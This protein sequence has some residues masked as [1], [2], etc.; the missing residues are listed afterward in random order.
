MALE[1]SPCAGPFRP[2]ASN[3][4]KNLSC[5]EKTLSVTTEEM[6][7]PVTLDEYFDDINAMRS[8]PDIETDVWA[9]TKVEDA[10]FFIQDGIEWNYACSENEDDFDLY[11]IFKYYK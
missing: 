8:V 7:Q 6:L 9:K 3:I 4:R 5:K 11:T 10:L 1:E 2:K